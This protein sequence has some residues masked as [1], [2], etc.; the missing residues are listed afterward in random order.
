[1]TQ[2]HLL[3][4]ADPMCSWCW[5]FAPVIEVITAEFGDDLPLHVVMGGLRPG[6]TEPMTDKARAEI[7]THWTHVREATG[8]PIDFSLLD[9]TDFVYDTEPAARAVVVMRSAGA[10][11][12]ALQRIQRAFYAEGRDVT[13]AEE[14]ADLAAEIG[15]DRDA[16]LTAFH[17]PAAHAETMNDFALSREAGV[18][19]FPTL[20]VGTEDPDDYRLVANGYRPAERV[21]PAL[22]GWLDEIRARKTA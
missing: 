18:T 3:Y 22:R 13:R 16:F 20:L 2:P 8:Q 19:G 9:R 15:A 21:I 7:G 6:T 11:L 1:M 10:A 4:I 17:S 12:T 5:G 14:L